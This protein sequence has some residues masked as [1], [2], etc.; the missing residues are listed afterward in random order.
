M[1]EIK[2]MELDLTIKDYKKASYYNHFVR[3]KKAVILMAIVFLAG[4]AVLFLGE[5]G[6]VTYVVSAIFLCY[7]LIAY[8]LVTYHINQFVKAKKMPE[9]TPM[10]AE[11]FQDGFYIAQNGKR[12]RF[13][14]NSIRYFVKNKGYFFIYVDKMRMINIPLRCLEP[15]EIQFVEQLVVNHVPA[16]RRKISK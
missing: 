14:W 12:T 9:H 10:T 7:P 4:V 1:Q 3:S 16:K 11:F 15:E 13:T 5:R 8:G 6:T 2:K